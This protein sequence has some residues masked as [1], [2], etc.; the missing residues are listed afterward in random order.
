VRKEISN[1]ELMNRI[2]ALCKRRGFI[3]QSS[4][5]YGG[6]A[7]TWDYGPVGVEMKRNIKDCWWKRVV[8]E[9]EDVVG[10]DSAIIM[11]PETWEASGHLNS[12]N[13]ALIDCKNCS[14]S[15]LTPSLFSVSIMILLYLNIIL[16]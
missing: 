9:R 16:I 10:L 11:H 5:I 15:L 2:I 1:E 13:D 7:N 4:E 12:F 3:Y 6:Q 8:Q 14:W